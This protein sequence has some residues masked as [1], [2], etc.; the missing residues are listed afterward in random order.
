M[1]STLEYRID[2]PSV[3][4]G[5]GSRGMTVDSAVILAAGKSSQFFPPLYDKPKGLF[6]YQGEVL[7]ERQIRQLREA[8]V[9]NIAVVVGYEKERFFYL[10]DAFGVDLVVSERWADESNL[11]SLDLVRDRFSSGAFLCCADHWYVESPFIDFGGGDRSVR[12]VREQA[13]ATRE[14]VVDVRADRCLANMRSGA[15]S[16][17][18]MVG[19]AYVTP[20]WADKFFS[21]YDTERGYIGVKGLLWE[22]FWGRHINELPLYGVSAPEGFREFDSMEELGADGVL[23]NVS[24]GAVGNICR[25]L[26]C[27]PGEISEIKPL[28]AGLTNVS[29]SFLCRGRRYVYRH[30]GAS[31]SALVDRDAE[32][33]AEREA[34]RLGIDTSVIDISPEGWKLSHY[35]PHV[36][37]FDYGNPEDIAAGVAQIR[38]FHESGASCDKFVD[39]L[40]EGDRLLALAAPKKGGVAERLASKRHGLGRVWHHVEL[41]EWPKVLCHNDT[42][43]V[44][45]IVGADGLCMIDWEYAGM[46]D[47]MGDLATMVVR[48]GLSLEKG[49]EILALY[50]GREPSFV[51]RRHAYGAFALTAWYWVCWCLFKDT[52]GEDGFFMLPSWRAL[53][54]YL[55]MALRM[56]EEK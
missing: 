35:V 56:Y 8:G 44:N 43:A 20:E 26:E 29:F 38:A 4:C 22:Q 17:M 37:D 9:S 48:D 28:N 47:P 51:E 36:R 23:A 42:Y 41:D 34:M 30:P 10:E 39:L 7:I 13:D 14:L 24:A 12:M 45:W 3:S 15:P 31:S 19:A 40:A 55:P 53:D 25:L 54:C 5:E 21:L 18:C 49:D 52:L 16:G 2:S 46:N 11:S 1:T 32:C 33:V 50:F 6:E 27:G